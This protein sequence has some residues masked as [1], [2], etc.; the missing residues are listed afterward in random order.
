MTISNPIDRPATEHPPTLAAI[1]PTARET[2]LARA[3]I[4]RLHAVGTVGDTVRLMIAEGE[5]APRAVDIP[6]SAFRLLASALAEIGAGRAVTMMPLDPEVTTQQAADILHVSRPHLVAMLERGE[7]PFRK[8]GVQ[9]RV[10]FDDLMSYKRRSDADR[11]AAFA[12]LVRDGQD[13]K[14]GYDR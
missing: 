2:E 1:T 8:V 5:G 11:E 7:I 9:R 4:D 13:L 12:A 14:L 10:R 6:A 3:S